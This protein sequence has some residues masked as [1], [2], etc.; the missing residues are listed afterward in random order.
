VCDLSLLVG[1]FWIGSREVSRS[2]YVV[3]CFVGFRTGLLGSGA[4]YGVSIWLF[5][6][7]VCNTYF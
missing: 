5:V 7:F 2:L 6:A 1:L 3:G 4:G